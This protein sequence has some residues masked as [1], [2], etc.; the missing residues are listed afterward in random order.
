MVASPEEYSPIVSFEKITSTYVGRK[1]EVRWTVE[2]SETEKDYF[3]CFEGE[4]LEIIPY[5]S[6]RPN[7]KDLRSCKYDVAK[8]K[9]DHE[10]NMEDSHVPLNP[11]LYAQ[12]NKRLGWNLVNDEHAKFILDKLTECRRLE[13]AAR[14][15]KVG[16]SPK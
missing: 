10:F 12:E 6:R 15:T 4:I 16:T 9:W 14:T 11:D 5:S 2:D 1:L 13:Q 3:H 7:Y 8:V